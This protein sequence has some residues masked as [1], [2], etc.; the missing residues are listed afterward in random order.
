MSSPFEDT[1]EGILDLRPRT[2]NATF[3][4]ASDA[5]VRVTS[6]EDKVNDAR[7][8]INKLNDTVKKGNATDAI[9]AAKEMATLAKTASESVNAQNHVANATVV[10]LKRAELELFYANI[11]WIAKKNILVTAT[12]RLPRV[13]Q[14]VNAMILQE[15]QDK[16]E[17]AHHDVAETQSK[18]MVK[19]KNVATLA[20]ELIDSVVKKVRMQKISARKEKNAAAMRVAENNSYLNINNMNGGRT[21]RHRKR[22]HRKRTHRKRMHHK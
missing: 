10:E 6:L 19:A 13:H 1:N 3:K 2:S 14:S 16:I 5:F 9:D 21:K 17:Y 4:K 12:N 8:T 7:D 22:T 15:I 20:K 18:V 11:E